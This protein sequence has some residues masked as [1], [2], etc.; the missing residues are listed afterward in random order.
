[1]GHTT[2]SSYYEILEDSL[3]V[4]RIDPYTQST[5]RK[6]LTK[7]SKYLFF[8][9]GVRRV[10][11]REGSEL[12]RNRMGELFEHYVGLEI[13][14]LLQFQLNRPQLHF[15]R[16]PDG[17]EVDWLIRT[18]NRLIPVEVKYRSKVNFEDCKHINTFIE[19]YKNA[20]VG[21]VVC[22]A[23]RP[24]KISKNIM[25]IPWT[26]IEDIFEK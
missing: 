19:E 6:K 4:L 24:Y 15:W 11:A 26:Q 2:V 16:D 7:S 22:L 9:M 23:E 13:Y 18:G 10:A 3:I 21:Y 20:S 8:D 14:R 25:A 5:T 1:V 12:G 17:P